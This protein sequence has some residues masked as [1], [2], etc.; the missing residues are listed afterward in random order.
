MNTAILERGIVLTALQ[1][2][3]EHPMARD[4]A[5]QLKEMK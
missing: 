2:E 5:S 1:N 4:H 3:I